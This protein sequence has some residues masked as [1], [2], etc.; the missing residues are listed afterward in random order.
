MALALNPYTVNQ[1]VVLSV[2]NAA[3]NGST[4]TAVLR[5]DTVTPA[6]VAPSITNALHM[7]VT[8]SAAAG[9][10]IEVWEPGWYDMQ[11]ACS[12]AASGTIN[13]GVSL[14]ASGAGLNA[15]PVPGTGGVLSSI[16]Q[17]APAA[18]VLGVTHGYIVPV[19]K[20]DITAGIAA[21]RRGA[22]LRFHATDN[23]GAT[24]AA[25]ITRATARCICTRILGLA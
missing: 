4:D 23:A 13:V 10:V 3:S 16:V 2:I 25:A 7:L 24:V 22:V 1:Q 5:F 15:N 19:T 9:S 17:T 8:T 14:N 6:P 12:Q 20:A 21:G 11:F 18:T